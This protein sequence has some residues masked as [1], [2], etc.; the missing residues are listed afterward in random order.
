MSPDSNR[1]RAF[2]RYVGVVAETILAADG[3]IR[4]RDRSRD[5][6]PSSSHVRLPRVATDPAKPPENDL[7]WVEGH[8]HVLG[9]TRVSGGKIELRNQVGS[10]DSVPL[11]LRR[12]E[13]NPLGG[14]DLQVVIG[15]EDTPSGAH[16]FAVGPGK[17]EAATGQLKPDF[18]RQFVVR[19]DGRVGVAIDAPPQLLTLGGDKKTRLEIGR[20]S[21]SLP[22]GSTAPGKNGDGSFAINQQSQGSDNANADFALMRDGKLRLVLY[23]H[24]T[25]VSGPDAG[26]RIS[27][28]HSEPNE[29]Q[30]M[31][32]NA[33]GVHV[34]GNVNAS[35]D[36]TC[37]GNKE[38]R[39][40][41]PLTPAT[42]C[43]V[44]ASLEGPESAVFYRGEAQLENGHTTVAMPAYFE[45]LTREDGRTVL[46][47]PIVEG[48]EP[49]SAL[50]AT[51]VT[52]DRFTVRMITPGNPSQR[53][54]WEV[55]ALRAD[56]PPLEVEVDQETRAT[57]IGAAP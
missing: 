6:D 39:I 40:A 11:A 28:N 45:A 3:L 5:P 7:A 26:V 37:G 31:L 56:V 29:V 15:T 43:L 44:H 38:F 35:K 50:A 12:V 17:V 57:P 19:D 13:H 52:G 27:V 49:A 51:R 1:I 18:G 42:K 8:L 25:L 20:I 46:L 22:W 10:A 48:D 53:F 9:D 54:C 4:L 2:R 23:E 34:S 24:G 14:K 41:H 30:V 16:V 33:F 55:K 47:T 21:A 32:V 36:I